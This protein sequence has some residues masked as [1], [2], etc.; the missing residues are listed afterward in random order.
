LRAGCS[1]DQYVNYPTQPHDQNKT[2]IDHAFFKNKAIS[3]RFLMEKALKYFVFSAKSLAS[4]YS[5][6]TYDTNINRPKN[7]YETMFFNFF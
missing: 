5:N 7:S 2:K 3:E 6:S 4:L 1:R